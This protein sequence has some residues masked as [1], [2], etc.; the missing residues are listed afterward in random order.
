MDH[1]QGVHWRAPTTI[2]V[3]LICGILLT[4]GH[5]LF[6][7]S[8]SRH[9]A[10][11]DFYNILGSNFSNQQLNIAGG[12]AFALL[13]KEF[14]SKALSTVY[15]QLFWHAAQAQSSHETS[16]GALDTTSGG[17]TDI[18]SLVKVWT[19]KRHPLMFVLAIITWQ[20]CPIVPWSVYQSLL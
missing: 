3:S 12:T 17:L 6:Y 1:E 11:N 10:P 5:H 9:K 15:A 8:L 20:V 2:V 4:I 16:L 18:V 19:W 14:L 13:V 7:S